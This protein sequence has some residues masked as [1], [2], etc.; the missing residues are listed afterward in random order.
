MLPC[1]AYHSVHEDFAKMVR[2]MAT[3]DRA[4][5]RS[6]E[7]LDLQLRQQLLD[8]S[9]HVRSWLD[10]TE[11]P[12]HLLR[13]EDMLARPLETFRGAIRFAGLD[14]DDSQIAAALEQCRF[15]RLQE[16]ERERG[17]RERLTRAKVFFREGR[18]GSWRDKLTD[19]LVPPCWQTMVTSC[20]DS[21]T[22][23]RT[24]YCL[25]DQVRSQEIQGRCINQCRLS[26]RERTFFRGAKD[27]IAAVSSEPIGHV[28]LQAARSNH[29][30]S[31]SATSWAA[32]WQRS[33]HDSNSSRSSAVTAC[34]VKVSATQSV[35]R[36]TWRRNPRRVH[37]GIRSCA[38]C[39]CC[40]SNSRV[41][42]P[43]RWC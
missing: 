1:L 6:K 19:D 18:S 32:L 2:S 7:G 13:Y 29:D 15:E 34:P 12:V 10:Q 26:L 16:K 8:W 14:N 30:Q 9:G 35:Q 22:L 20:G 39:T 31:R 17:F 37:G 23:T 3:R 28:L 40:R 27:D 42:P 41:E 24:M 4:I 11:V 38:I 21:D 36:T 5:A 33:N 43:G 25:S